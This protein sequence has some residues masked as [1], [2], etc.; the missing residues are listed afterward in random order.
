MLH[1]AHT[2]A[3]FPVSLAYLDVKLQGAFEALRAE[4]ACRDILFGYVDLHRA[5]FGERRELLAHFAF[6]RE[7]AVDEIAN[8]GDNKPLDNGAHGF[9]PK[10]ALS[11]WS[12]AARN[13]RRLPLS[14]Q[15]R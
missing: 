5:F 12:S 1:K 14:L 13:R 7:F 4:R 8:E 15:R 2:S 11:A 6:L 10:D 9:S 3:G